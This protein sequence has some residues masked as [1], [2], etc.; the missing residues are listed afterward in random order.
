MKKIIIKIFQWK[1]LKVII[2]FFLFSILFLFYFLNLINPQNILVKWILGFFIPDYRYYQ[3]RMNL[4]FV[5]FFILILILTCVFLIKIL[6]ERI[7]YKKTIYFSI[8]FI[9][10]LLIVLG[11]SLANNRLWSEDS[12]EHLYIVKLLI[13]GENLSEF[14]DESR[15]NN[16]QNFYYHKFYAILSNL[17][18][19]NPHFVFL[20]IAPII[21][22]S[23]FF[24]GIFLI[25]SEF[26]NKKLENNRIKYIIFL[27]TIFLSMNFGIIFTMMPWIFIATFMPLVIYLSYKFSI[28]N[29]IFL[30]IIN[31]F[32]VQ[33]H[34]YGYLLVAFTF[35]ALI[36]RFIYFLINR[37]ELKIT[38]FHVLILNG[39]L[40]IVMFLIILFPF[41]L[42]SFISI[43]PLSDYMKEYIIINWNTGGTFVRSRY[44]GSLYRLLLKSIEFMIIFFV[45][46]YSQFHYS[47]KYQK[48]KKFEANFQSYLR[49][50]VNITS[51][52]VILSLFYG[53]G[54]LFFRVITFI[55]PLYIFFLIFD[56]M[57]II[58]E[59][60]FYLISKS[61]KLNS[62]LKKKSTKVF[63][64]LSIS[65][66]SITIYDRNL[67]Y[68]EEQY[69][70][71]YW[72]NTNLPEDSRFVTSQRLTALISGLSMRWA[73]SYMNRFFDD[74]D[75]DK[76]KTNYYP[77]SY[78]YI[79]IDINPPHTFPI[80]PIFHG[81]LTNSEYTD[82]FILFLLKLNSLPDYY[83][84]IYDE[85]SI[86][87]YEILR[88][89]NSSSIFGEILSY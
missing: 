9:L 65:L 26:L 82:D 35:I 27:F 88:Y 62:V 38:Y 13:N 29:F 77:E 47:F 57:T 56:F 54:L 73:T 52:F 69:N 37:K 36:L 72:I 32:S 33:S 67:T 7:N 4:F 68:T 71:C 81:N 17:T 34:V 30:I 21:Q 6:Y 48:K 55:M 42:T 78:L 8:L 24:I 23:I 58:D 28:I 53:A 16:Y 45:I 11:P 64:I 76:I 5:I 3:E 18:G 86:L 14:V 39:L 50:F 89:E 2:I 41:I 22:F 43:L 66:L 1:F 44:E 87:I 60:R 75:K 70:A 63:L 80:L 79:F 15:I 51:I 84:L 40:Y 61:F 20:Y 12:L 74:F 85:N 10:S 46:F 31:F 19:L 83:R 59:K 49:L 25:H